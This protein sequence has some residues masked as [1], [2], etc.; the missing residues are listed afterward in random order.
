[1]TMTDLAPADRAQRRAPDT[2]RLLSSSGPGL[3]THLDRHGRIPKLNEQQVSLLSV[4]VEKSGLRGRGG[5]W[6][7]IARKMTAV[8][9]QSSFKDAVLLS[10][11]PHMVLDGLNVAGQLVGA[12]RAHICVP[13]GSPAA[14]A[15][16]QALAERARLSLDTLPISL[17][18]GPDRYVASE[19]SALARWVGGGQ[20]IPVFPDRPFSNGVNGRPTLVQNVETLAHLALIAHR[21]PERFRQVGEPTAPGSTLITVSGAVKHRGVMEAPT[22]TP[23]S[24]ILRRAGGTTE[25]VSA[26]LTGGYGGTWVSAERL[27]AATWEPD[28]LKSVGGVIGASVLVALPGRTCGLTETARALDWLAGES[29]GQCGPCR[30]GLSSISADFAMLSNPASSPEPLNRIIDR[31]NMRLGLVAG[32]G[33]CRLPDG[34]VRLAQSAL[35]TF[36]SEVAAHNGG[37]CTAHNREPV[38][39]IPE[40][41]SHPVARPSS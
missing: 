34:A 8:R 29:A 6:F 10:Q 22:G 32:R 15:I 30:F 27:E 1:M 3:T 38:L 24:E 2:Q 13:T 17:T 37:T 36:T 26:Y 4:A 19:E 23:I 14:A 33:A 40:P 31:L 11:N 16:E 41:K 21:G 5:G 39:T 20:A 7:P 28:S 9:T 25:R 35:T 12:D 18:Y